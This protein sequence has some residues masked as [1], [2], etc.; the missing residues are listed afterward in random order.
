M[1]EATSYL[2]AAYRALAWCGYAGLGGAFAVLLLWPQGARQRRLALV[3]LAGSSVLVLATVAWLL[4]RL[5]VPD[6]V[7]RVEGTSAIVRLAV[8]AAVGGFFTDLLDGPTRGR[9]RAAV[10]LCV[11]ALTATMLAGAVGGVPGQVGTSLTGDVYVA[12]AVLVLGGCAALVAVVRPGDARAH[13]PLLRQQTARLA[14]P[15]LGVTALAAAVHAVAAERSPLGVPGLVVAIEA[16]LLLACVGAVVATRRLVGG[17][18]PRAAVETLRTAST[19]PA[20][21]GAR[22][23]AD[24]LALDDFAL[25]PDDRAPSTVGRFERVVI[26]RHPAVRVYAGPRSTLPGG[27]D[28]APAPQPVHVPEQEPEPEQEPVQELEPVLVLLPDTDAAAAGP[29]PVRPHR[30]SVRTQVRARYVAGIG[31]LA[32]PDST[33]APPVRRTV[34]VAGAAEPL[35]VVLPDTRATSSTR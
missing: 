17:G 15:A 24:P 32:L 31:R 26:D 35:V 25:L 30:S 6:G 16:L 21:V 23:V 5:T 1:A 11:G 14:P 12:L 19:F 9:R 28:P 13:L 10:A 29:A 7:P 3:A 18:G 27:T 34:R 20:V 22:T 2:D 33:E 8:L 4:L